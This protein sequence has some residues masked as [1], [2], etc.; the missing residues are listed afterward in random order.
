MRRSRQASLK[1]WRYNTTS[2]NK[3]SLL[4]NACSLSVPCARR[5]QHGAAFS[6]LVEAASHR[7]RLVGLLELTLRRDL[8][9]SKI[10][11]RALSPWQPLA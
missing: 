9:L 4:R 1:L 5:V 6:P 8:R 10:R 7:G 11:G 3:E 2:R